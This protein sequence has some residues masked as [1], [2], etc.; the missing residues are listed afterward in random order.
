MAAHISSASLHHGISAEQ[1]HRDFRPCA[2]I[3]HIGRKGRRAVAPIDD[4]AALVAEGDRGFHAYSTR[5]GWIEYRPPGLQRT[6]P[7]KQVDPL[8][9][10]PRHFGLAVRDLLRTVSIVA[11]ADVQSLTASRSTKQRSSTYFARSA[12]TL[13]TCRRF[14]QR[15]HNASTNRAADEVI[16][17]Y[18]REPWSSAACLCAVE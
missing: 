15:S 14:P 5:S 17:P 8:G 6:R 16:W 3:I 7:H 10:H 11:F 13:A 18:C 1:R 12:A 4:R 2:W 9:D